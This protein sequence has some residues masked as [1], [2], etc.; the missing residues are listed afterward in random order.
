MTPFPI[1]KIYADFI[2]FK[3]SEYTA[4]WLLDNVTLGI[5][6]KKIIHT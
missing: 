1:L 5:T 2:W 3:S 4:Y 6:F